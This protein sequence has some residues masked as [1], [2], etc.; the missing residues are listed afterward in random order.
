M[1]NQIIFIDKLIMLLKNIL[2]L[3]IHNIQKKLLELN[4]LYQYKRNKLNFNKKLFLI[5]ILKFK[6]YKLF[7]IKMIVIVFNNNKIV[8]DLIKK[9]V[10]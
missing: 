4:K 6:V 2:M 1:K 5:N 8:K 9:K 10:K 7:F 3:L